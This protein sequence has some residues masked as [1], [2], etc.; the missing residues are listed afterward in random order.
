MS[1]SELL[2]QVRALPRRER[3]KV[4][5]AILALEEN[6]RAQPPNEN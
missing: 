2:E 1:T 3:Q 4:Y 6:A 5:K